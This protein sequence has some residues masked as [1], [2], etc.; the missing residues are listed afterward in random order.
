MFGGSVIAWF[1]LIPLIK[2]LGAGLA[3]PLFPSTKLIADMTAQKYGL[4]ILNI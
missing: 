2:Y 1:G 3:A 4:V